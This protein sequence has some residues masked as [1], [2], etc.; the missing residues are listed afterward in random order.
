M[1]DDFQK[2][3]L[4]KTLVNRRV[5]KSTH[6]NRYWPEGQFMAIERIAYSPKNTI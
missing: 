1:M 6:N 3:F 4:P 2:Q 5:T